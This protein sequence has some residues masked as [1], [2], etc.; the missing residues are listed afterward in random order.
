MIWFRYR[1]YAS[2]Y[3]GSSCEWGQWRAFW[4]IDFTRRS[5]G[6]LGGD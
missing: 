6:V 4:E 5:V 1:K 2:F 3:V